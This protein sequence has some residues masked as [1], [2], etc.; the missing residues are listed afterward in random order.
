MTRLFSSMVLL[1]G[2]TLNC[3]AQEGY[4]Q[5]AVDYTMDIRFDV[6]KHQ[7]DGSQQLKYTNNSPDTLK[8]VF[9]HLYFN[10]FQPNSMMD[11]RSRTIEDPDKR[12]GSRIAA[13][14]PDEIGFHEITSLTQDGK[15]VRYQVVGTILEVLLNE[16]ILP[17]TTVQFDMKFH[18]Q[19]PIQI[20]RSGRDNKE[21][22]DYTLTQWY[23]KMAE[24]D[25]EGWHANPYIGREFHGVWGNFDVT[26]HMPKD[27]TIG[28]TGYLQNPLEIGHGYESEG[29]TVRPPEGNMLSWHFVAP[30]VHDFAWAADRDYLH[31]KAQVPG[32]PTLHFF[33]QN[34]SNILANW[35]TLPK[36]AVQI[37]EI[38][39]RRFGVYPYE[40]YSVIQGGD[41][42]MEYPMATMIV[43]NGSR[44]ALV[45]VTCHEAIHSWYQ[46]L[47]ATNESLYPWIDEGFTTYA[48][49]EVLA[50]I[51]G[52]DPMKR[53]SRSYQGYVYLTQSGKQ[54]PLGTHADHYHTNQAYG[55]SAYSM[56]CVFLS[57]LKYVVGEEAFSKGMIDYFN[58]WKYKHPTPTDFKK[59]MEQTSGLELDWYFRHW[60]Q[61]TKT[62]DYA[63]SA[64]K[65]DGEYASIMLERKGQFPMPVDVEIKMKE[66]ETYRF[67]IPLRIM[68]GEK[69]RDEEFGEFQPLEDWAWTH[70]T[71]GLRLPGDVK[72]IESIAIDPTNRMADVDRSNNVYPFPEPT[73]N[74]GKKKKKKSKKK[75]SA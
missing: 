41:G 7:F 24:Y 75:K 22:I 14:Q 2:I 63:I 73:E 37:F 33:F 10:A 36:F 35:D 59:V 5:Q 13:L 42:G 56:G 12:V 38:M 9:Y 40:Q 54:E 6:K 19:V 72:T 52:H 57:Q 15:E 68:R 1:L 3:S 69:G 43:G 25:R 16:P 58:K 44:G 64:V 49:N 20:R 55:I 61:T 60:T 70:P 50:E 17:K 71:Y 51:Y 31:T 18:S 26:I 23:P 74:K 29:D 34:D 21:G 62:I 30:M 28:G 32:G 46:G 66:G 45:S 47:L 48:Q 4:W 27:Y 67:H 11:V 65:Q 39:N 8:K 53:H